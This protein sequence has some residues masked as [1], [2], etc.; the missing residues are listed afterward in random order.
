VFVETAALEAMVSEMANEPW[1]LPPP[2][3]PTI[4]PTEGDPYRA[5]GGADGRPCP[6]CGVGMIA[7]PLATVAIDRCGVHGVW[8]DCGELASALEHIGE[9]PGGLGSWLKRLFFDP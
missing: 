4:A 8:F 2:A 3:P 1:R 7:E 9:P 5:D 6:S